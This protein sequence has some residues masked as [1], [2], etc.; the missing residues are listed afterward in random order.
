[1]KS[2]VCILNTLHAFG[3]DHPSTLSSQSMKNII[4]V[5]LLLTTSVVYGQVNNP[6][7][8]YYQVP[9]LQNAAFSGIDHDTDLKLGF[10]RQW[11]SFDGAPKDYFFGVNHTLGV[12]RAAGDS[13]AD[14]PPSLTMGL[15]GYISGSDYNAISNLQSG[16]AYAVHIPVAQ[17]YY[18]SFGMALAYNRSKADMDRYIVRDK[19]DPMYLSL[20]NAGG[21][22]HYFDL[23][24]GVTVHSDHFYAG[25]AA[26]HLVHS[27]LGNDLEGDATTSVR[28]TFQAGYRYQ[29]NADWE[30]L[31]AVLLRMEKGLENLYSVNMKA[32]YKSVAWAGAGFRPDAAVSLFVGYQCRDSLTISYGYDISI[33]PLNTASPGSHEIILGFRPF[34]RSAT[35]SVSW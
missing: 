22:L 2:P 21:S 25:Y 35:P 4:P 31:P 28:H 7:T 33:G 30:L 29:L 6:W 8:Q 17:R 16:F 14:T 1:M 23:D 34:T 3:Y 24:A 9:Y 12:S 10:R 13:L 32:R 19:E 27:R 5:L 20:V 15:S 18:L 26:D 11:T